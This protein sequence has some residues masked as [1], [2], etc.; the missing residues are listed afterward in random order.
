M[1]SIWVGVVETGPDVGAFVA[2]FQ[3]VLYIAIG[4]VAAFTVLSFI[5]K[6]F[7]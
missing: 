7:G 3:A 2:G 4:T 1:T 6:F 5:R